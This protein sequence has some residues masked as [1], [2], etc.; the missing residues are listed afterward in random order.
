VMLVDSM[1]R[2]HSKKVRTRAIAEFR[3]TSRH[4]G[5]MAPTTSRGR[6]RS[7]SVHSLGRPGR[8]GRRA[9]RVSVTVRVTT[10]LPVLLFVTVTVV[11]PVAGSV[12]VMLPELVEVVVTVVG[13][14]PGHVV[15]LQA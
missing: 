10:V 3:L 15:M 5:R 14:V 13:K 12:T 7:K 1:Y 6:N 8:I 11:V 9:A 2:L 4:L